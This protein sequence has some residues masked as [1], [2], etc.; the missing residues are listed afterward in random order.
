[1][2]LLLPALSSAREKSM[3]SVCS[4]NLR[5]DVLAVIS[6]GDD[7][8]MQLPSAVDNQG[9]YHSVVL[10]SLTFANM[11]EYLGNASNTLYCPNLVFETGMMGG[12]NP[13]SGYTIGYSYLAAVTLPAIPQG[14]VMGWSGPMKTT[15][16][17]NVFADANYW[18]SDPGKGIAAAP[19]T[20]HGGTVIPMDSVHSVPRTSPAGSKVTTSTALGAVGGN[21]GSLDGSV[22]WHSIRSMNQYEASSDD[23]FRG[24]W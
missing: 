5:Q 14:P 3:R 22:L 17:T 18:S 10:S 19:H 21:V 13:Q 11:K 15:R 2:S 16:A 8:D 20:P 9:V 6:Y 23:S 12:Y 24:N 1:M 4:E 7:F